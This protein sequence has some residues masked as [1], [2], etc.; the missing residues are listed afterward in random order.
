MK[1]SYTFK[2]V[3]QS[4]YLIEYLAEKIER[5][6]KFAIRLESTH[7]HFSMEHHQPSLDMILKGSDMNYHAKASDPDVF[8]AIDNVISK[9]MR[10]LMKRKDILR[11][12]KRPE[13]STEAVLNRLN[14]QL[15]ED[16]TWFSKN[17]KKAA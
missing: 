14:P 9:M 3:E 6:N 4:D 17:R 5:F 15:D 1:L 16:H 7:C 10:Q 11:R 13:L 12:R 8:V 2:N